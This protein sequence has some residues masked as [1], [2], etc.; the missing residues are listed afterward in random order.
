VVE[1]TVT[2]LEPLAQAT[3]RAW[4]ILS[5]AGSPS[6]RLDAEILVSHA[7]GR[8]RSWLAAHPDAVLDGMAR[9]TLEEW[10]ARRSSGE[11][12]AYLRGWKEWHGH[13]LLTDARA[14]IPRPETEILAD[15]AVADL[16]ARMG[17]AGPSLVVWDV[18]TGSGA[19][20]LV[21][22]RR[23][24]VA[25]ALGRL[26]LVASDL[27]SESLELATENFSA[28]GLDGLATM[29]VADLLEPA[30]RWLPRPNV[31]VANLP[32][33]PSAQLDG[34]GSLGFEPISAL[35]GGPEG[36]DLIR[37]LVAAVPEATAPGASVWLE[38]GLG[39]A[40]QVAALAGEAGMVVDVHPDLAGIDRVVELRPR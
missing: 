32:Y 8:D 12:I 20:A 27:S 5:A 17:D 6:A 10:L 1:P 34:T 25:L 31:V 22:S 35:D 21:L 40:T 26:R 18:G 7:V 3:A 38:V 11:P 39:Q 23:F 9:S 14:L 28:D 30:G 19:I 16:A 33:V 24:R 13:R 4:H 15:L 29:V 36:L 37:R 2:A